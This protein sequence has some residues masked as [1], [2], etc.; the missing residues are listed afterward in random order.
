MVDPHSSAPPPRSSDSLPPAL[1][2]FEGVSRYFDTVHQCFAAKITPGEY[3]ATRRGEVIITVLGSCVAAC[4][5]CRRSGVGG[6]NH[7]LLPLRGGNQ[8]VDPNDPFNVATRYG[9]YAMESLINAILSA[10]G[11]RSTL[12]AKLFGGGSV[13]PG[14]TSDVGKQNVAFAR[15]YLEQEGIPIL[16]QDVGGFYPRKVQYFPETGRA[17]SK[18]LYKLHNRTVR[19]REEQLA[20]A[21]KEEP[22]RGDVDLF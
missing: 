22:V 5:R 2:G 12:E 14:M 11:S 4:I 13:I 16:A 19:E 9:N 1:A 6:M 17:R 8:K 3:Y 15:Q 21:V 10:G 18:K 20:N 7:F